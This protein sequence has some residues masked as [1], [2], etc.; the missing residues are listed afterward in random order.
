MVEIEE[1]EKCAEI[2][3]LQNREQS[4]PPKKRGR[5]KSIQK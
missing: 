1:Y 5:N 4:P 3:K 2:V